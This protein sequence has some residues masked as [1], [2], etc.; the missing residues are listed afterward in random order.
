MRY[1]TWRA[2][3]SLRK[4]QGMEYGK[5]VQKLLALTFLDLGADRVVD[6]AIQGIDLEVEIDG[7]RLAIEVKTA[8]GDFIRLGKKDLKGLKARRNEGFETLVAALGGRLTD[9]WLFV[10]V[11][12]SDL[13]TNA[14]LYITLLRPFREA[15]LGSRVDEA[16]PQTVDRHGIRAAEGGQTALNEVLAKHASYA[17]A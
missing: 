5:L 3:S 1:A 7:R 17:L 6:R 14:D 16:F 10:P 2:L 4:R 8:E 13:P 15:P 12:G 9:N 11:P